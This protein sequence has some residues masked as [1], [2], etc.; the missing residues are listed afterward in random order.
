MS[1]RVYVF[2]NLLM[3]HIACS[4]TSPTTLVV[5]NPS[6]PDK[7][8]T[9]NKDNTAL[10]DEI[11]ATMQ[12]QLYDRARADRWLTAENRDA[13]RARAAAAP[14]RL[15]FARDVMNP[16]FDELGVSHTRLFTSD[17]LGFYML[18]S[19]FHTRDIHSPTAVHI[20][21]QLTADHVIRS[22]FDGYPADLAG[23]RRGDQIVA[24]DGAPY[25]SLKQLRP[26]RQRL[27]IRRGSEL[28]SVAITPVEDSPHEAM[29]RAMEN[30][31]AI[32]QRG[33][34]RVG[35]VH[36]WTGT[37]PTILD[38]F[39]RIVTEQFRGVDAVILDL[40]GGFGGAWYDYIDPFYADRSDF[41]EFSITDRDGKTEQFKAEPKTNP[42]P[43]LGPLVVLIDEGTRSGKE[44]LAHQFGKKKRATVMGTTTWGAFTAGKGV[45]ADRNDVDYILYLA[46]SEWR[47]DGRTMEGVGVAPEIGVPYPLDGTI[48]EDPQRAR[49]F[50]HAF[51]L[52]SSNNT[53]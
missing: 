49:A 24:V 31:A 15:T 29:L 43:Y 9:A 7:D 10:F 27:R 13:L 41:F 37:S 53:R 40:R 3:L 42:N 47:V 48:A 50:E 14:D 1:I 44:A 21:V 32:E 33:G 20:G 2:L 11:W 23:L 8:N 35:Y 51:A 36:L 5:E 26:K 38:S 52:A 17:V 16:F 25:V 46:V 19:L 45:F 34:L 22:V 28:R 18:R 4:T 6:S 12:S 39:T 30:S